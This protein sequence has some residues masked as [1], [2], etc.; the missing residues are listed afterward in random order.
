M[1]RERS[2]SLL[3]VLQDHLK[4]GR[5]KCELVRFATSPSLLL[6]HFRVHSR[7]Q[8]YSSESKENSKIS[9]DLLFL[10]EGVEKSEKE[11]VAGGRRRT[12]GRVE[13]S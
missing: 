4:R 8:L 9:I 3:E 11:E 13:I 6:P 2:T 1:G 10:D 7:P 5:R 12:E